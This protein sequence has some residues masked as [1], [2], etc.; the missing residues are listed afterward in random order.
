MKSIAL[1]ALLATAVVAND[2]FVLQ[3]PSAVI[4]D[5][6]HSA[7]DWLNDA[8]NKIGAVVSGVRQF[9]TVQ[10]EGIDCQFQIAE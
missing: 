10:T 9:E 6:A 8:T 1:F 2:Q 3:P 4:T 7:L 5:A